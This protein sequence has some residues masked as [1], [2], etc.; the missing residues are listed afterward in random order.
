MTGKYPKPPEILGLVPTGNARRNSGCL[1]SPFAP[2]RSAGLG[3]VKVDG[4]TVILP[5]KP[6]MPRHKGKVE[7]GVKYGQDNALKGCKF[8]TLSA[9]NQHLAHWENP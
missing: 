7:A 5:C 3:I 9:Q 8:E 1:A 4:R 2:S 6:K